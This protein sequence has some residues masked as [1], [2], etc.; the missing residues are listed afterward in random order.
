[1]NVLG[2]IGIVNVEAVDDSTISESCFKVTN[3]ENDRWD[4]C[5][6]SPSEKKKWMCTIMKALG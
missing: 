1:M 2:A 6:E 5:T 4:L 3:S